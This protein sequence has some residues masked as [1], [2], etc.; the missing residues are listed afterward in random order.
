MIAVSPIK[1]QIKFYPFIILKL[2]ILE[3][4]QIFMVALVKVPI[5]LLMLIQEV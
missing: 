1:W 2:R 4:K 3:I 5:P